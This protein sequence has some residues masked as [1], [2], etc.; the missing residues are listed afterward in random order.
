MP[1]CTFRNFIITM[2]SEKLKKDCYIF[3][4][5]K[6]YSKNIVIKPSAYSYYMN[7]GLYAQKP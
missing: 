5:Q 1:T 3:E 6:I 2:N 7:H 4:K